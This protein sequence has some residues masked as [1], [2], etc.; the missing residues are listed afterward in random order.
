MD[1]I[2]TAEKKTFKSAELLHERVVRFVGLKKV[3][4]KIRGKI[5]KFHLKR[6]GLA[7]ICRPLCI[8]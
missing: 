4:R 3:A 6:D 8:N 5:T 1:I 2:D 7:G